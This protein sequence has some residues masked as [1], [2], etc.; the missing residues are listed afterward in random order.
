[1]GILDGLVSEFCI[2]LQHHPSPYETET[3]L[4]FSQLKT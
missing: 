2:Q 4:N 1:M 3:G